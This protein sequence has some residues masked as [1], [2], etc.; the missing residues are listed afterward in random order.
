MSFFFPVK[1]DESILNLF[2]MEPNSWHH[3]NVPALEVLT[4]AGNTCSHKDIGI[5]IP[6]LKMSFSFAPSNF[7]LRF[8]EAKMQ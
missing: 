5:Q 1:M 4:V 6:C 7:F 8:R 3:K 2:K